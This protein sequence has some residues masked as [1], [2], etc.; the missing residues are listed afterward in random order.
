MTP[1]VGVSWFPD[2]RFRAAVEPVL[3]A[4]E[5]V[6]HTVDHG[7]T[8]LPPSAR[9]VLEVFGPLGRVHGHC[10][11]SSPC[12]ADRDD[13]FERYLEGLRRH[14][15]VM[16]DCSDHYGFA[17]GGPFSSCAP[18]PVPETAE[19]VDQLVARL[20][21][22][23]EVVGVP[24][25]LENLALAFSRRQALAQ[26][27]FVAAALA[28]VDGFVHLDLHNLWCQ[29]R[30]FGLEPEELLATWPLDRVWR[31]HVSGGSDREGVRRDTHDHRVPEAVWSMLATVLPRVP[32]C[33]AVVLE[34]LPSALETEEQRTG[35]RADFARL[36]A[37]RDEV[38]PGEPRAPEPWPVTPLPRAGGLA[39]LRELQ[40]AVLQV[41][42]HHPSGDDALRALLAHPA[43]APYR[44]W[45]ADSEPRMLRV[46]HLLVHRWGARDVAPTVGGG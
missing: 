5:A 10:V 28:R 3:S 44:D 35:W 46:A 34:Q 8:E 38:T 36:A 1:A 14:R 31:L 11:G 42:D 20:S 15:P 45:V 16:A 26:G 6:E 29:V 33:R 41:V 21:R 12:S 30:N 39:E 25:G 7:F 43:A 13:V 17:T 4:V 27:P 2:P 9:H 37:V 22:V 32:A 24:V 19:A 40:R 23:R 18:L